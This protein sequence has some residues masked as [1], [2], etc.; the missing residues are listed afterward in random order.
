LN[1]VLLASGKNGDD[2]GW[3]RFKLPIE[4]DPGQIQVAVDND[5]VEWEIERHKIDIFDRL[6]PMLASRLEGMTGSHLKIGAPDLVR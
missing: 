5:A 4:T 2:T 1:A 6:K 3:V